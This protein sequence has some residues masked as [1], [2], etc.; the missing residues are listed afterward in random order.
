M[1]SSS[2]RA[3]KKDLHFDF[4]SSGV[5]LSP[6]LMLLYGC[7]LSLPFTAPSVASLES[8]QV[9]LRIFASFLSMFRVFGEEPNKNS[10]LK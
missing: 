5:E 10:E 7:Y 6:P 2:G 1:R 3:V 4:P 9:L 8:T